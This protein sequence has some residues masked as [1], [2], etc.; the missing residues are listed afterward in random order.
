L[1]RVLGGDGVGIYFFYLFLGLHHPQK[2]FS[3][4]KEPLLGFWI[5]DLKT[6]LFKKF[7]EFLFGGNCEALCKGQGLEKKFD[8]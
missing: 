3:V 4:P 2:S 1:R 7:S 5:L 6:F 8:F